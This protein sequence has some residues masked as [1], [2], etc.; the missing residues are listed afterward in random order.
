MPLRGCTLCVSR[1]HRNLNKNL[2]TFRLV[3][4]RYES[5]VAKTKTPEN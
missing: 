4:Q 3:K 2:N 5:V 1:T